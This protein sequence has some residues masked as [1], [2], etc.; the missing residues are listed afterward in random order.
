MPL[1]PELLSENKDLSYELP[2]SGRP[3]QSGPFLA[4]DTETDANSGQGNSRHQ[5]LVLMTVS[6]GGRS[7]VL[8]PNQ[9]GPFIQS[10]TSIVFWVGHNVAFDYWTVRQLLVAR[11]EA[12]ALQMWDKILGDGRFRDTMI[13]DFL[14]RLGD[15]SE[16]GVLRMRNL[17]DVAK[18][19]LGYANTNKQDDHR[20]RFNELIG[21][22]DDWPDL[23]KVDR[24]FFDYA[25]A[26]TVDT[27]LVYQKVLAPKAYTLSKTSLG[28]KRY[29]LSAAYGPLTEALQV[30]AAVVLQQIGVNG[31]GLDRTKLE[32]ARTRLKGEIDAEVE[33]LATHHSTMLGRYAR[34]GAYKLNNSGLPA[35]KQ[36]AL[37]GYLRQEAEAEGLDWEALEKT[38]KTRKLT[39]AL[40]YWRDTLRESALVAHW[41]H[42]ADLSKLYQFV[43]KLDKDD[44]G[45]PILAVHPSYRPL[46]RT[47]RTSCTDPNIQQMPRAAWFR[48]MFIARPGHKL[49]VA[50]YSAI[51]L[52]TLAAVLYQRYGP[53][54]LYKVLKEGRDPHAYTASLVTGQ[55]YDEVK[56]GVRSEKAAV[57]DA[58][59]RGLP[60]P[61]T[62]YTNA[63]QAA[64]AIN[65]GVPGGL[66]ARRLAAYAKISYSV[67]MTEEQARALRDKLIHTVYPELAD[68]LE[69]DLPARLA[70][71]LRTDRQKVV[72]AFNPKHDGFWRNIGLVLGQKVGKKAK[73]V[74][75]GLQQIVWS[76]L[77]AL[78]RNPELDEAL[79]EWKGGEHLRRVVT[80]E[81]VVTLTGR[82]RRGANYGE[83]RNTPFQ[84]SAA[85]GAKVALWELHR[86]NFKI[87]AFVH[88]EIVTEVPED[89]VAEKAVL[90]S[91][92]MKDAMKSVLYCDLPVEV[93][94]AVSDS[95][96][97]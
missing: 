34:T 97:K 67:E 76:T 77:A 44:Q 85:D 35:I 78:N 45:N 40:D 82:V 50:D 72:A 93:E 9:V 5:R 81:T 12:D 16:L 66:G 96:T 86:R 13:L 17:E 24:K 64:K 39:I 46:V 88:D 22:E 74:S 14:V 83:A 56:A 62:P 87:V 11:G 65:F 55:D 32:S 30:R 61:Q 36:D 48:S 41:S 10:A 49:I 18:S 6:V 90:Q 54:V 53:T 92:V 63:R 47:G 37:R 94:Y 31:M 2:W 60:R 69:D 38:E 75:G 73:P 58:E 57:K 84:G 70:S 42:L 89:K 23:T 25:V 28:G 19:R 20:L 3:F 95:W 33:W 91:Q 59:S 1:P 80:G 21:R 52:T 15:L 68:Y 51:E 7:A 27:A 8:R 43:L 4:F 26:D 79:W 71:V 29:F